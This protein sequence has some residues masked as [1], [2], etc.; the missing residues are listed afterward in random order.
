MKE[1]LISAVRTTTPYLV[2]ILIGLLSRS[3]I[4][5]DPTT[6]SDLTRSLTVL[7][8]VIVGTLYYII[9][10]WLEVNV[11]PK[12]G[13]LLGYAKMPVYTVKPKLPNDL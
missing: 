6:A 7:F 8:E 11:S 12:F 9:V 4:D 1:L 2:A 13:W 5:V 3:G 10:R